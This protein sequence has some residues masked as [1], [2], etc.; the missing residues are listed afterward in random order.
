MRQSA[1]L[2]YLFQDY[3]EDAVRELK[4]LL[5]IRQRSNQTVHRPLLDYAVLL[6]CSGSCH[7]VFAFDIR[8]TRSINTYLVQAQKSNKGPAEML[9]PHFIVQ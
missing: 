8:T 6:R 1:T 7:Q 2:I 9:S 4:R 3:F 5:N